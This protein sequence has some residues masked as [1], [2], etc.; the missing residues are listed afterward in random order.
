M[1]V[2]SYLEIQKLRKMNVAQLKV[3]YYEVF[4]ERARSGHKD[5]LCKKIAWRIQ[6]LAEGGLSERARRRA[7]EIANDADLRVR[8]PKTSR[9]GVDGQSTP[10]VIAKVDDSIQHLIPLP[11]SYLVREFRGKTH[12]IKVL[13]QGF[14][15]EDRRYKSLSGVAREITGVNWNGY[16]FFGLGGKKKINKADENNNQA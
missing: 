2:E 10:A 6:S 1:S 12:T 11:G 5:Y 16:T 9:A 14:E 8:A 7:L 13:D 15:Y 3:K 4:G